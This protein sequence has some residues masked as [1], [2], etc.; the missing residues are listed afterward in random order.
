ML[1]ASLNAVIDS[2]SK[3]CGHLCAVGQNASTNENYEIKRELQKKLLYEISL[4]T[5]TYDVNNN[6]NQIVYELM[7]FAIMS[8]GHPCMEEEDGEEE[9]TQFVSGMKEDE[10]KNKFYKEITFVVTIFAMPHLENGDDPSS[11][12]HASVLLEN[13]VQIM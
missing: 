5:M 7:N 2:V 4:F 11:G 6:N 8:H 9:E 13:I 3:K 12:S 10:A 1:S